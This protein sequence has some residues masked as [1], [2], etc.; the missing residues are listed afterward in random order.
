MKIF[1]LK[2]P[3]TRGSHAARFNLYKTCKTARLSGA[4]GV[5]KWGD[6]ER[7]KGSFW[8]D[9]ATLKWICDDTCMTVNRVK[10]ADTS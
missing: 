1:F 8:G 3:D 2:K 7:G 10:T 5:K 4:A 6:S 9:E